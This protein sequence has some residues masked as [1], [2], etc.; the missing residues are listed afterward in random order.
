[1][2]D[3][4][5][6]P[7]DGVALLASRLLNTR[8]VVRAPIVLFRWGLGFVFAGRL[9][10]LTH[11]GRA[12]GRRRY[13]VL[14]VVE[15]PSRDAVVIASGFG[16]R[17]QWYRNLEAEPRCLVS[18]GVRTDV[19]AVARLLSD[20]ESAAA[21]DRYAARYPRSWKELRRAI[22]DATGDAHSKIPI[23]R[24]E[25]RPAGPTGTTVGPDSP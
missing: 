5:L 8:F 7:R 17:A 3:D 15:R 13:A 12:S 16:E 23:V 21:L 2:P 19:P 4:D 14:E 6:P 20:D 18:V 1:M 11:R 22:T 10:M 9:M 24:L 25:L